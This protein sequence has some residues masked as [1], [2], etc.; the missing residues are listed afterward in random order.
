[1][2]KVLFIVLFS[3]FFGA[4]AQINKEQDKAR[5]I[6]ETVELIIQDAEIS[7]ADFTTLFDDL[8]GYFDNPIN[9]NNA[10]LEELNELRLLNQYQIINLL[11]YRKSYGNILTYFELINVDGF[12]EKTIKSILPFVTFEVP[13]AT[14]KITIKKVINYGKSELIIRN[15]RTLEPTDAYG[16]RN[17]SL[18]QANRQFYGSPDR[19]YLRYRYRYRKNL[20]IGF[21]AEKDPGE[22]IFGESQ[23]NGFDFYSAHLQIKD[24]GLIKN[25]I[26]GDF[27]FQAAQGLTFWSGFGFRKSPFIPTQTKRYERGLVPYTASEE[28]LFLRGGA[29]EIGKEKLS[30]SFFYSQKKV[31]ANITINSD[32]LAEELSFSSVLTSGFHRTPRELAGKD[33]ITENI[34]G[35]RL[36]AVVGKLRL[37]LTAAQ[38]S[39]D[40]NFS[41]NQQLYQRFQNNTGTWQNVG[42]DFDWMIGNANFYGEITRSNNGAIAYIGGFSGYLNERFTINSLYRNYPVNFQSRSSNAFGEKSTN[43]NESGWYTAIDFKPIKKVSAGGYIDFYRLPW[44]SFQKFAPTTGLEFAGN[45]VYTINRKNSITLMYRTEIDEEN[46]TTETLRKLEEEKLTQYRAQFDYTISD[47]LKMRNRIEFR[48]YEQGNQTYSGLMI[49]HDIYFD[50]TENLQFKTRFALFDSEIYDTRIY[51]YENDMRYQFTVPAYNGQGSRFYLLVNYKMWQRVQ[52]S[53]R[54][55]QT[56][57][58]SPQQ[59]GT[60]ADSYFGHTRSEIKAQLIAKF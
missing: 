14:Q 4:V 35:G 1:M 30:A 15:F 26:V 17:D 20:S 21:T 27:Q 48:T 32:S 42:A 19:T 24:I 7:D 33:A 36:K 29:I 54:Y 46:R 6:E 16:A 2:K 43:Y 40:G 8:E 5:I 53:V 11:R 58:T 52:L 50:A 56:Y 22:Q 18:L 31:D 9:V 10:T 59:I 28:N 37:G 55:A 60:G 41:P 34:I 49:Y 47:N 25:I 57:Y 45:L 51:A 13:D 23:P 38:T 3:M 12:D 44:I 39:F